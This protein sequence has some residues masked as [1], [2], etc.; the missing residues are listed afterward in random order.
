[1]NEQQNSNVEYVGFWAR[2][3]ASLIDTII[4]VVIV[5]PLMYLFYGDSYLDSGDLILGGM[6]LLLNYLLPII[7]VIAFWIL[8]SATPGKMMIKAIIV[9][10]NTGMPPTSSQYII[11]YFAYIISIIPL[12]LGLMWVIWDNRK[13]GWHDK[14]ART[15]VIRPKNAENK[16]IKFDG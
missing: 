7:A 9:D 11:R 10:A 15:V 6:D 16:S 13:Q 5:G 1:M 2:V 14:L 3:L 12:G 4:I 8:K